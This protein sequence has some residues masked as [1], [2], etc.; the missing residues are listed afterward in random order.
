MPK[1]RYFEEGESVAN[2]VKRVFAENATPYILRLVAIPEVGEDGQ[3]HTKLVHVNNLSLDVPEGETPETARE[4]AE[5]KGYVFK[6]HEVAFK[7]WLY[8]E[9]W[10]RDT[11][12]HIID[13][14]YGPLDPE[15]GEPL[16]E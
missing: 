7:D 14:V 2:K 11:E 15:T 16:S 13:P 10:T 8:P 12:G 1:F 9:E 4:E 3:A 6:F 5:E